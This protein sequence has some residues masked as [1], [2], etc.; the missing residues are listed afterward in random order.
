MAPK[1]HRWRPPDIDSFSSIQLSYCKQSTFGDGILSS[2]KL[3]KPPSYPLHSSLPSYITLMLGVLPEKPYR[4]TSTQKL[5]LT[6]PP[7]KKNSH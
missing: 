6:M 5:Y 2:L 7:I 3:Y 4:T 1:H